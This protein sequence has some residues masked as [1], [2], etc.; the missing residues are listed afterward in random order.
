MVE[1]Y[2]TQKGGF[3]VKYTKTAV[4]LFLWM[5]LGSL[6]YIAVSTA[7]SEFYRFLDELTAQDITSFDARP[8]KDFFDNLYSFL[9]FISLVITLCITVYL[10]MRYDN[11]KFE[12]IISKTDGLYEIPAFLPTYINNFGLSDVCSACVNGIVYTVPFFFVP[13]QFIKNESFAAKLAEPYKMMSETFGYILSPVI[14][15]FIILLSYAVSI[16]LAL[17]YYRAKWFSAFSEV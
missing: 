12:F 8:G 4:M 6:I 14:L 5:L 16:L 1:Y 2:K 13:I 10:S 17:K 3:T 7:V 11:Y 15:A 9:W